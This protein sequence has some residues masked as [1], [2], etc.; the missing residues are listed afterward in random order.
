MEELE[1]TFLNTKATFGK[2]GNK[3]KLFFSNNSGVNNVFEVYIQM[4]YVRSS[5]FTAVGNLLRFKSFLEKG[6][7]ARRRAV[8]AREQKIVLSSSKEVLLKVLGVDT[9]YNVKSCVRAML[10]IFLNV[11]RAAS[12]GPKPRRRRPLHLTAV[13]RHRPL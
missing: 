11:A 7:A 6:R 1:S 2:L 5:C 12:S 9:L 10:F 3:F 4:E 13:Q 8:P